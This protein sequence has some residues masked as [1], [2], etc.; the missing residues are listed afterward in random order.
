MRTTVRRREG[1]IEARGGSRRTRAILLAALALG[2]ALVLAVIA[3]A[4]DRETSGS[5]AAGS[6]AA[7]QA[8]STGVVPDV[9]FAIHGGAGNI[10]RQNTPPELEA[11]YREALSEALR[12]GYE[13]VQDGGEAVDAVQAAIVFL[14]DSPLFNAGKGAVFTT[15]AAHELDA[16]IMDGNSLDTGAVTGVQHIKNPILLANEVMKASRHVMFAGEGAELFALNRGFKLVTQDYFF[17]DRRWQS[18]LNAKRGNSSFN[19]GIET[20][21]VGAV[22]LDGEGDLAAGTSTGGLTNKP[23]GRIGDSPI[24]GA[25]TYANND[26]VAVSATGTG[27]FFIRQV[28]THDISALI[29][30]ARMRVDKAAQTAIDKVAELGGDGGVIALDSRGNLATPFNTT[31]MFR[32]HV[33]EDG[34]IVVKMF[35]D[36]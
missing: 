7:A 26:T 25:G 8:G 17:T 29:D 1:S 13:V 16:S 5:M 15:D 28:V 6:S 34:R 14:E 9:V 31:G 2:V 18:L 33:T 35:G 20:G 24:I 3:A 27:E 12:R 23:V 10:T 19:F 32:G 21:T 36:E 4:S 30:Y 22:A 11:Q